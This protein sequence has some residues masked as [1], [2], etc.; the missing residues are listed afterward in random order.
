MYISTKELNDKYGVSNVTVAKW[1]LNT[2]KGET[3]LTYDKVGKRIRVINTKENWAVLDKLGSNASVKRQKIFSSKAEVDKEFYNYFKQ[4]EQIEI[5]RDLEFKRSI[6]FKFT[7]KGEGS[8]YWDQFYQDNVESGLYQTP[9]RTEQVLEDYLLL[10]TEKLRDYD[11]VNIVEIGPGN[12]LPVINFVKKI[13]KKIKIKHYVGVDI[14]EELLDQSIENLSNEIPDIQYEK[15]IKDI[16][17]DRLDDAFVH[18]YRGEIRVANLVLLLGS[19]ILNTQEPHKILSNI[20]NSL[21]P[22]D[23]VLFNTNIDDPENNLNFK[24]INTPGSF[25]QGIWLPRLMGIDVERCEIN[26]RFDEVTNCKAA[27]I[28]LDKDYSILFKSEKFER[29]VNLRKK[30]MV[31]VWSYIVTDL[32]RAIQMFNESGFKLTDAIT[33]PNK[34]HFMLAVQVK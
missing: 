10:I 28:T 4:E 30:E 25:V 31:Y 14:S 32:D 29:R 19:T 6:N 33:L 2:S 20:K 3:G 23:I 1:L 27:Y 21:S 15:L 22:H 24:Y 17:K 7:Y 26:A 5:V 8:D 13:Y 34:K 11:E 12:A 18:S 16:E 9:K